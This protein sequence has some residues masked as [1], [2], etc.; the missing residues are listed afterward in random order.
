MNSRTICSLTT[1]RLHFILLSFFANDVAEV[2]NLAL[3]TELTNYTDLAANHM[4]QA[5]TDVTITDGVN[6]IPLSNT[7][8]A[9]LG[10]DDFSFG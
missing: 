5:G 10:T 3:V 2:I 6:S 4:V 1:I 7:L 9:D 8:L